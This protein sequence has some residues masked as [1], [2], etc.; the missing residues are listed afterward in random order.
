MN[1]IPQNYG[2]ISTPSVGFSG[3]NFS[4]FSNYCDNV[5]TNIYTINSSLK[6]L[7]NALKIIG[8]KKDNQGLRNNMLVFFCTS[9]ISSTF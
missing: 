5:V 6:T 4:E 7:E 3:D 9:V 2:S 8:T 1:R